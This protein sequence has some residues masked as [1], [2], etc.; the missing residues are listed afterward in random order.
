MANTTIVTPSRKRR[1]GWLRILA[2][3][4]VLLLILI[5]VAYFVV[6]NP[7]FI[8]GV[9]LPRLSGALDANVTVS[10]VSLSPS[11]QI[12]LRDLKV[13]TKGQ[14]P[15][16]SAAE[17]SVRYHLWDILGGNLH[18]DEIALSS[19]T[20]E[21][22]ENPDGSSNLDPLLKA[23]HGKPAEAGTPQPKSSKAPRID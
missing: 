12:V 2:W 14:A 20:V 3:L 22:V 16:F 6:T 4:V 15:V 13:Q 10:N 7:A 5:V 9:V 11:K 21:L 8:K 1:R 19:P 23:L 18:V 17:V